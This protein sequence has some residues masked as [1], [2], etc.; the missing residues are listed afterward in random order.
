MLGEGL[1]GPRRVERQGLVE[2]ALLV[3]LDGDVKPELGGRRCLVGVRGS[4]GRSRSE[5]DEEYHDPGQGHGRLE[6]DD[7]RPDP[8]RASSVAE[9]LDCVE[10]VHD[11]LLLRGGER[12]EGV[13]RRR[14]LPVVQFDCLRDRLGATVVQES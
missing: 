11:L 6:T 12:F 9:R 10:E 14:G 7:A 5:R 3:E 8:G 2:L 1:T 4:G 13:S